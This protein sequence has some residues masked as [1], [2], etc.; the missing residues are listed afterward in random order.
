MSVQA[1]S[2]QHVATFVH[3]GQQCASCGHKCFHQRSC[4]LTT[5]L[6]LQPLLREAVA[7]PGNSANPPFPPSLKRLMEVADMSPTGRDEQMLVAHSNL[8]VAR[9]F[10]HHAAVP[11]VGT[12]LII[13]IVMHPQ[14]PQLRVSAVLLCCPPAPFPSS[15]HRAGRASRLRFHAG[16]SMSVT[17]CELVY[18]LASMSCCPG[19]FPPMKCGLAPPAQQNQ[20]LLRRLGDFW[21]QL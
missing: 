3:P 18:I 20:R 12:A 2:V 1:T 6:C 8:T 7:A 15:L 21:R 9:Y 5:C 19:F 14:C 13:V 10:L 16:H 11:P 4:M 17:H